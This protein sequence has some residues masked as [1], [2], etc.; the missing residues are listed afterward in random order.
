[1]ER[2][3]RN[4]LKALRNL[5]IL[6]PI[7]KPSGGKR[8][9]RFST[10][11]EDGISGATVS[12]TLM[13]GAVVSSARSVARAHGLIENKE[14]VK[15]SLDLDLYESIGWRYLLA[16]GSVQCRQFKEEDTPNTP[17]EICVSLVTVV[18]SRVVEHARIPR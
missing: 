17:E 14:D 3:L 16:D 6:K 7:K 2:G 10:S 5:N 13:H 8:G 9:G 11:Q 4:Y 12:A 15:V 1:M 18:L